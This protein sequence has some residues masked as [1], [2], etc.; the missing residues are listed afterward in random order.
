M[1]PDDKSST[2][3]TVNT[4]F[5]IFKWKRMPFGI[6]PAEEIFQQRLDQAIDGFDGVRTVFDDILIIGN[7]ETL[8]TAAADHDKNFLALEQSRSG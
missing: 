1:K 6:S 7:G 4:P 5:G 2:L 8:Q 3:T